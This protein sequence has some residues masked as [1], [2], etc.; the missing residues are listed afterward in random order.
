M[1]ADDVLNIFRRFIDGE[2]AE[3]KR[4]LELMRHNELAANRMK[5]ATDIERLLSR[6]NCLGGG[7]LVPLPHNAQSHLEQIAANV[8]L[9]NDLCLTYAQR[10]SVRRFVDEWK[11]RGVLAEHGVPVRTT[12]LLHGPSGNGKT[13]LAQAIAN[14]AELPLFRLRH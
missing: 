1:R 12:V 11:A 10:Q 4:G 9:D 5:V 3:A 6:M 13:S 2:R 14:S 7:A 8:S